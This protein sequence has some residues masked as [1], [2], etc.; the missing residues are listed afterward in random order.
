MNSNNNPT[1]GG[2]STADAGGSAQSGATIVGTRKGL[3]SSLQ[4]LLQGI[5]AV[6][7][8]GSSLP[9]G[10]GNETKAAMVAE[11]TQVLA[12]YNT[13]EAQ[14]VAL[15]ATRTQLKDASS[16][17]RQLYTKLKEALIAFYG[18][19]SPL[20]PQFGIRPRQ[21]RRP[22]TSAQKVARAEKARLTRAARHT[23]GKRQ[24]AGVKSD[25]K[26][27]VSVQAEGANSPKAAPVA[28]PT[29]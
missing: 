28:G 14:Q 7:P 10:S 27:A 19:G 20:L 26:L 4:Q 1:G 22:L 17:D 9:V 21:T 8:D 5:E 16:A 3:R 11:I 6:V 23:M 13:A 15:K 2:S 29:P 18:K 24:R 12:V 25:A